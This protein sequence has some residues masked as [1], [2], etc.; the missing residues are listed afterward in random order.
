MSSCH[1]TFE[2][3]DNAGK[4]KYQ[5][6]LGKISTH[7]LGAENVKGDKKFVL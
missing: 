2:G 4:L 3:N 5:A 6:K 1:Y 7:I